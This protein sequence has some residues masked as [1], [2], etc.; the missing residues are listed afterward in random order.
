MSDID[1]LVVGLG[2]GGASAAAEAARR[3]LRVMGL[4]RKVVA[5]QPV[6]CAEFVPY[7]IGSDVANLGKSAVQPIAEMLTFVEEDIADRTPN[8]PGQMIDRATFDAQLVAEAEAAGAQIRLGARVL[9]ISFEGACRLS[10]G[11]TLKA[12]VVIGADGPRS[13]VG[14][15]IGQVNETIIESR[16]LTTDLL[17]PHNATDIFLST[18]IPGGYGWM[19]PKGKFANIGLGVAG[20]YRDRLKPE[21]EALH[22][23]LAAEGRVGREIHGYTGGPIPA[24]GMVEPKG[25]LGDVAVLLVGDAAGLTHPVTG[26]G[27]PSAVRSGQLA[28]EAAALWLDGDNEALEDYAEELEDLFGGALNRAVK[29]RKRLLDQFTSEGEI[30]PDQLRS[31]W[32]A[33]DNYWAAT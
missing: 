12:A 5:G 21:L 18:R 32:I 23:R 17:N 29:H 20:E 30:P 16:Q 31:G 26:A 24:G 2:P 11:E 6:Q 27:I 10:S 1:V 9:D 22:A 25:R 8:F 13:A 33:Y 14:R 3:G 15:A 4:D 28:G 19:F 7:M